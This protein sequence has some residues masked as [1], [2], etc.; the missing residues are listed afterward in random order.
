MAAICIVNGVVGAPLDPL[1]RG[2]HYG[3]GVF[4]TLG[5]EHGGPRWLDEH[6][7][8]L[9]SDAARL[10]LA[11]PD[12]AAWQSDLAQLGSPL[13]TGVV[14]LLLTRGIGT[15]GYRP[16]TQTTTRILIYTPGLPPSAAWPPQG[17]KLRLCQLRL[18]EQARL[19]GIKHLNRLENVL[20]RSEWDDPEIHEGLLLDARDR[21]ISGVM[22]N[23]FIWR[24]DCLHTPALDRCG[25]AG[26]TRDR[27]L[28]RATAAGYRTEIRDLFLDDLLA[29]E[30][31]MLANSLM[32]L[33]HV[34]SLEQHSWPE[35]IIS[36]QLQ[37][38]LD[39]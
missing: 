2:L 20:A 10:G 13:A 11:A 33:R 36:P 18:G 19:A 29:A 31:L 34:A 17:L 6:L 15:R 38:L 30:E 1:D 23:L 21:V 12:P 8:K 9:E 3:D 39:A 27:L 4:R 24:D 25:V 26:V 35:S 7:H 32:G 5:V 14:K 16:A 28:R 22:S 37:V